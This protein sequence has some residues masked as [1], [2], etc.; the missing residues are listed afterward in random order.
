M[1][2]WKKDFLTGK[3]SHARKEGVPFLDSSIIDGFAYE[4]F[5]DIG[6]KLFP[7]K[8]YCG[9]FFGLPLIEV[10]LKTM[11]SYI[12]D[13]CKKNGSRGLFIPYPDLENIPSSFFE[14]KFIGFKPYPDLVNPKDRP[15]MNIDVS[16]FDF[17]PTKVF[18]FSQEYGLIILIHLP[19]I[20]RLNDKKNIEEI[21][22]ICRRY[23]NIKVILAHAGRS[24]CYSDIID[25]ITYLK[26]LENLYVDTAMINSFSVIDV[27]INELGVEKILYGSDLSV[28]A[29]KGKNVDINNK[30]YFITSTPRAWSLSSPKIDIN[31][32]T[33][34][35]YETIR[36]IR[37]ASKINRLSK[38][39][40]D[41][42][43]YLNT[44]NLIDDILL[45]AKV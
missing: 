2:L 15:K 4:D 37:V 26:D 25:S 21:R 42:I 17:I 38:E 6:K 43:F 30:H 39:H 23:P 22:E 20:G 1:H 16:I 7:G 40:I 35:I 10:N 28:S 32:M 9:L 11:N 45:N 33:F 5:L 31:N 27:L 24:Y 13:V 3:I 34:F 8:G 18:E 36:A 41:K 12:S 44:K 29:I 19:R 14:N